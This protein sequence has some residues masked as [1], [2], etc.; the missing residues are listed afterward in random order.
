MTPETGDA[1]L[2]ALTRGCPKITDLWLEGGRDFTDAGLAAIAE[3]WPKISRLEL[4]N[5]DRITD[6]G[7][8][9]LE[10]LENLDYLGLWSAKLITDAGLDML[11]GMPINR[12]TLRDVEFSAEALARYH[13]RKPNGEL[14]T[15]GAFGRV[16]A[17]DTRLALN[18][19]VKKKRISSSNWKIRIYGKVFR[20]TP[21]T[22][23]TTGSGNSPDAA[24]W[25]AFIFLAAAN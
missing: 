17:K 16:D 11:A 2:L 12:I 4:K 15:R 23:P 19:R 10:K 18:G 6:E 13:A 8:R 3:A 20:P 9:S 21:G 25:K 7:L 5:A 24:I 1:G 14:N 22:S